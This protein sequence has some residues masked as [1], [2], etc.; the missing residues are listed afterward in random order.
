[1]KIDNKLKYVNAEIQSAL[2]KFMTKI[3]GYHCTRAMISCKETFYINFYGMGCMYKNVKIDYTLLFDEAFIHVTT[4]KIHTPLNTFVSYDA[5]CIYSTSIYPYNDIIEHEEM[6]IVDERNMKF[7]KSVD[8]NY[9]EFKERMSVIA[10][11]NAELLLG[12]KHLDKFLDSE[13][14]E[15]HKSII[16]MDSLGF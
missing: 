9:P 2:C 15:K 6:I 11:R 13:S 7:I 4:A 3:K 5:T 10:S 1:M 12:R 16:T 14:M 8:Q